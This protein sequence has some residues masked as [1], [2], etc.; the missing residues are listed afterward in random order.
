[1]NVSSSSVIIII[2][3]TIIST[4]WKRKKF[5]IFIIPHTPREREKKNA[6]ATQNSFEI[7]LFCL[8]QRFFLFEWSKVFFDSHHFHSF[9]QGLISVVVFVSN[10]PDIFFVLLLFFF[11][12]HMRMIKCRQWG[13]V[14]MVGIVVVIFFKRLGFVNEWMDGLDVLRE[15]G[16]LMMIISYKTKQN[17]KKRQLKMKIE[18]NW[19]EM[20][21]GRKET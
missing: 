11:A 13:L 18:L 14:V 17:K 15:N 3:L 21:E 1:M 4:K 9:I 6:C 7:L 12:I 16:W 19:I 8:F 20:D 2:F 5:Q 10:I